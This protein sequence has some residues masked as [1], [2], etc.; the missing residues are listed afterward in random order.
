M[1]VSLTEKLSEQSSV[2]INVVTETFFPFKGGSA[3]RYYEV[4]RRLSKSG[5]DVDLYTA[6]LREEWACEEE[7]DGI[8]VVRSPKV[9]RNLITED[10][11]R[12]VSQVLDFSLWVASK[13]RNGDDCFLVE[14][15]HCP[16]FPAVASWVR[17]RLKK[18][19]LSVTFHEAWHKEW[20]LYSPSKVYPPIGI[21]LEKMLTWLP[22]IGIAVSNFTANRL[23]KFFKMKASKI[24]V[25]PNGV[26]LGLIGGVRS[27]RQ[28]HKIVYVGRLNPHKKVDWLLK[29][30]EMLKEKCPHADL[31][32]IGDGPMY[33]KYIKYAKKN[34]L[35][36][37]VFRGRVDDEEVIRALKSS[38]LYVL[39]SVREG[40]SITTLEAMASGTPQIVIDTEG[41]GAAELVS[42]GQSGLCVKPSARNIYEAMNCLLEDGETWREL[43]ENGIKYTS[44]LT[45]DNVAEQHDK[46]YKSLCSR[47][48]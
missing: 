24:M 8:H 3:K 39:P 6:R 48:R 25:I 41:N 35:S 27:K 28:E 43:S 4:F 33:D 32:L 17:S 34:H 15:N 19:L 20:Y 47:K 11:F 10:G 45:W 9:Y 16:I 13:L 30:F 36:H 14:A 7:I 42:E 1:L 29:A 23:M 26:D 37:V 46:L 21:M 2:K 18:A 40:Q 12:D 38:W 22:D 5:Y 44:N 31:E